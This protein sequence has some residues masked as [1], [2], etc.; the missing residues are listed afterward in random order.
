M[1]GHLMGFSHSPCEMDIIC[2]HP[3]CSDGEA[4][5]LRGKVNS[6]RIAQIGLEEWVEEPKHLH[7]GTGGSWDTVPTLSVSKLQFLCL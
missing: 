5:A 3:R 1:H 4:E 2:D 6:P 7:W